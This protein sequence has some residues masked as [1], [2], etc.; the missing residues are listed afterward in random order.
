MLGFVMGAGLLS[1]AFLALRPGPTEGPL[2]VSPTWCE[3]ELASLA[4]KYS[5]TL[6]EQQTVRSDRDILTVC[7]G[8]TADGDARL[9]VTILAVGDD[10]DR[11]RS[12]RLGR[13]LIGG[14]FE[15]GVPDQE[16]C[17]TEVPGPQEAVGAARVFATSSDGAAVTIILTVPP[18]SAA[19]AAIDVEA[20]ARNLNRA[21]GLN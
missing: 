12:Q 11:T 1:G 2:K 21:P 14:C 17:A 9:T 18:E 16:N 8:A 4:S 10:D 13:A 6:R 15:I 3:E 5:L 7:G 19:D 20:L